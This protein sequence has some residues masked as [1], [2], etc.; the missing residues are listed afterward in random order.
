[1]RKALIPWVIAGLAVVAL[2]GVIGYLLGDAQAPTTT[3]AAIE[4]STARIAAEDQAKETSRLAAEER[5]AGKGEKAGQRAGRRLGADRG[6]ARGEE[7]VAEELAAIESREAEEEA[8]AI[9]IEPD[10]S[11][12]SPGTGVGEPDPQCEPL[13]GSP[14]Y[15]PNGG[16]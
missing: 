13:P 5:A 12:C 1:M 2:V 3:D 14:D 16:Y 11:E 8:E 10:G 15:I 7:V 6:E 9:H 4:R